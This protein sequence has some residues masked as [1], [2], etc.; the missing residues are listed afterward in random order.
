MK[1]LLRQMRSALAELEAIE[2]EI[3][4]T[5]KDHPNKPLLDSLPGLQPLLARSWLRSL[6][7]T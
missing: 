1:S 5:Y 3:R 2:Q 7:P 4:D 6:V